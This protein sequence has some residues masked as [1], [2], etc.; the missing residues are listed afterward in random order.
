MRR[1]LLW[2]GQIVFIA[3]VGWF[4]WKTL[5]KTLEDFS[6]V[7]LDFTFHPWWIA[8]SALTILLTY[9]VLIEAWRRVLVGWGQHLDYWPAT[10]IWCLS[11]LARFIPGR[12]WSFAGMAMLARQQGVEIWAATGSAVVIQALNV[13]TGVFVGAV[14]TPAAQTPVTI[15]I[16]IALAAAALTP[17]VWP[18][19]GN[20]LLNFVKPGFHLKPVAMQ[21]LVLGAA[22]TLAAWFSYGAAFW[23]LGRGLFS[24]SA[25]TYG[26]ATGGFAAASVLGFVALFT[27]GGLGVREMV[28]STVLTPAMGAGQALA[29]AVG[30]RVVT[31]M[32][33]AGSGL[34]GFGLKP[35]SKE[36]A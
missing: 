6:S 19:L 16:G 36:K 35:A 18:Q 25:L 26:D 31:T 4:F 3:V 12:V 22:I 30:S 33:E 14:L 2:G 32:T 34:L 13:A 1:A 23:M 20:R 17:F 8:A 9:G 11:N 27:P 24:N 21:A 28:L 29:L 5:G 7:R 10:R 15:A